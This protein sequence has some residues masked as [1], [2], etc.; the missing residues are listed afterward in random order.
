[1]S[2]TLTD[3][4]L[5]QPFVT[6]KSALNDQPPAV[7]DSMIHHKYSPSLR[8]KIIVSYNTLSRRPYGVSQARR[9]LS[10]QLLLKRFDTVR[11]CL[12]YR[13]GLTTAQRE[14]AIRLLRYWSYYGYVYV[15]ESQVTAEPGCSKAT[16]WRTVK[17]LESLGLLDIVNRFVIRPHAQISNLYRLDR[18]VLVLAKYISEHHGLGG[19]SWLIAALTRAPRSTSR[20]PDRNR[21]D[22]AGP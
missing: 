2:T 13:L 22:R 1:M 9:V 10:P 15:K 6:V 19:P 20:A 5:E 12:E 11:D 21:G 14:V 4:I 8:K 16:Y 18:L 7:P 3:N 17:I